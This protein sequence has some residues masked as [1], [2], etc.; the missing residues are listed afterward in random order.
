MSVIYED[1]STNSIVTMCRV[2]I[3]QWEEKGNKQKFLIEKWWNKAKNDEHL[4]YSDFLVNMWKVYHQKTTGKRSLTIKKCCIKFFI[5]FSFWQNIAVPRPGI[6]KCQC[7]KRYNDGITSGS[8]NNSQN[9][10]NELKN[11]QICKHYNFWEFRKQKP[12]I[13]IV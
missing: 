4:R 9:V 7:I 11:V 13:I 10:L 2:D 8:K 3:L 1:Y 5:Y 12:L 6:S